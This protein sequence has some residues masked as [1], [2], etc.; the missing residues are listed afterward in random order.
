MSLCFLKTRLR[1]LQCTAV[2]FC[3]FG[4]VKW[5]N[6]DSKCLLYASPHYA[7]RLF[8]EDC[9]YLLYSKCY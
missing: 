7:L 4:S 8:T 3:V 2:R 1:L 9:N 5:I 6:L